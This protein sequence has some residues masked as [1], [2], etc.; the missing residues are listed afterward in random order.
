VFGVERVGR[1]DA[2]EERFAFTMGPSGLVV[3]V[4][5][6]EVSTPTREMA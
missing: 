2:V 1:A 5:E 4:T 3:K 6:R